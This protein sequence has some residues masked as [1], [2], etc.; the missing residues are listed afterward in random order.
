[1][2]GIK[3]RLDLDW[4]FIISVGF[5]EFFC[6]LEMKVKA[7]DSLEVYLI[8]HSMWGEWKNRKNEGDDDGV[9]DLHISQ[10]F[11]ILRFS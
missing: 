3:K 10:A 8:C 9:R 2:N 6:L 5:L 1:M 7:Y 11:E 4:N